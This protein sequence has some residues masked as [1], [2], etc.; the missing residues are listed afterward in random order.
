MRSRNAILQKSNGHAHLRGGC[1]SCCVLRGD[2]KVC[3][4]D[5]PFLRY[6]KICA[7]AVTMNYTLRNADISRGMIVMKPPVV[8]EIQPLQQ[9]CSVFGTKSV[10]PWAVSFAHVCY[11]SS[12]NI[13]E[14]N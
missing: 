11:I 6:Y 9:L 13:F 5:V 14:H 2:S 10:R 1:V 4:F 7:L 8:Q 3:Q 12:F